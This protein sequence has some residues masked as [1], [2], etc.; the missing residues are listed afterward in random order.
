MKQRVLYTILCLSVVFSA[1]SNLDQWALYGVEM[2][3]NS[4]VGFSEG[5]AVFQDHSTRKYGA[6]NRAGEVVIEAQFVQLDDFENGMSVAALSYDQKGI[7]NT[8]GQWLLEPI[9]DRIEK[10]ED[11]PG[12]YIVSKGWSEQG[13]FYNG[14]MVIPVRDCRIDTFNFPFIEYSGDEGNFE[15][16]VMT[17]EKW[18]S[19]IQQGNIFVASQWGTDADWEYGYYTLDGKRIDVS[20][21]NVSSKGLTPYRDEETNLYGLKN[22]H[23]G[24][25]VVPAKYQGMYNIWIDDVMIILDGGVYILYDAAGNEISNL[26]NRREALPMFYDDYI[27][28]MNSDNDCNGLYDYRGNVI[29]PEEYKSI[30]PCYEMD[31]YWFRTQLSDTDEYKLFNARTK[32]FYKYGNYSDGMICIE[33]KANEKFYYVNVATGAVIDKNFEWAAD[34]SEGVAWVQ[35]KGDKYGSLI[36]KTGKVVFQGSENCNLELFTKSSEGVL[37]AKDEVNFIYGYVRNPLVTDYVYNQKGADDGTIWK[38]YRMAQNEYDNENYESA[39]ELY[40][41]IMMCAPEEYAAVANYGSCLYSMGYYEEAIEAYSMA[42]DINPNYAYAQ[43]WLVNAQG[44]VD[45]QRAAEQEA[46]EMQ[47]S[48]RTATFWDA[49]GSFCSILGQTMGAY[50]GSYS[51]NNSFSSSYSSGSSNVNTGNYQAEYNRWEQR[52]KSNYE[53]LTNLGY[54]VTNSRNDRSGSTGQSMNTGNYVMQKKALRDAQ[55]EMRNIRQRASRAGVHI[56]QSK[57]ETATVSY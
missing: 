31:G 17:G 5:V 20:K 14:R 16:N 32:K 43:E 19:V 2:G 24:A 18:K 36:D 23:T 9:Y 48:E 50:S 49:L 30:A 11:H 38:W 26:S 33:D 8:R 40:Y 41:Q 4:S 39:K 10:D 47:A 28:M 7:I 53:T 25:I 45:A 51:Y 27:L 52:A 1:F 57:W 37:K 54:S 22:V 42:L 6:I 21:N 44:I 55:R 34:F 3:S 35:I 12:V 46:A 56:A 29:L 15:L 13:L